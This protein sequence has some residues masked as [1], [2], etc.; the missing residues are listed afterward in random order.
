MWA[1]SCIH[2][3]RQ[4]RSS[5][6][7]SSPPHQDLLI[8][9]SADNLPSLHVRKLRILP[10]LQPLPFLDHVSTLL[11]QLALSEA[12]NPTHPPFIYQ[13]LLWH[14]HQAPQCSVIYICHTRQLRM[15]ESILRQL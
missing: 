3:S 6:P 5:R 8:S 1:P 10:R 9:L 12:L 4:T 2:T 15:G 7:S 14:Q 11:L 13:D